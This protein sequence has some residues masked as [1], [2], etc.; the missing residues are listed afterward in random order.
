MRRQ[1]N[2]FHILFVCVCAV[3]AS[4][5]AHA[6]TLTPTPT[7][8]PVI[9][10][11]SITSAS[12][13][14]EPEAIKIATE[15]VRV[16]VSVIDEYGRIDPTLA[17]EDFL[18]IENGV[19]QQTQSAR[20]IPANVLLLL[21][22]GSAVNLAKLTSTT[23]AAAFSVVA[24]LRAGDR[25]AIVQFSD[26]VEL[27]QGW[28]GEF[29]DAE[30][31]LRTK[32]SSGRT[33]HLTD[34]LLFAANF[35]RETPSANRHVVLITDGVEDKNGKLASTD[36]MRVLA[37][38]G[39]MIHVISYTEFA[40]RALKGKANPRSSNAPPGSVRSSGIATIGIDPTR[41]PVQDAP[42]GDGINFD[43]ALRRLRKTYETATVTSE[44][45]LRTL[46]D[47]TGG[48]M[49]LPKTADE[50]V[51]QGARVMRD[52]ATQYIITYTPKRT[53]AEAAPDEKREVEIVARRG[54]LTLRYRRSYTVSNVA[55]KP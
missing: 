23:R 30:A 26:R 8:T 17:A 38:S 13:R 50:L 12:E 39:A 28:T 54:G 35:L 32:L 44:A 4:L 46:A 2:F 49:L 40:R 22:T 6:Q 53:L 19:Q 14:Q 15:E 33:A 37:Q 20:R 41:S 48:E 24:N 27:L 7:P 55:T 3:A 11:P 18:I 9:I 25:V 1:N 51:A 52:I 29:A 21:D 36:A 16:P 34:A 43:P 5:N 47:D 45:Q 42:R 31:V 10:A